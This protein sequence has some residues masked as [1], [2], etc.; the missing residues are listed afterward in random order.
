[1]NI[2]QLSELIHEYGCFSSFYL[3][4]GQLGRL[5]IGSRWA[6]HYHRAAI[7]QLWRLVIPVIKLLT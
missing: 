2:L 5:G 6:D 7:S 1:M 3:V 4:T